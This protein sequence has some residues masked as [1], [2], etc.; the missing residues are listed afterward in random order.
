M[1]VVQYNLRFI[2]GFYLPSTLE[3]QHPYGTSAEVFFSHVS[4]PSCGNTK[5]HGRVVCGEE[6]HRAHKSESQGSKRSNNRDVATHGT[7]D[8]KLVYYAD[9]EFCKWSHQNSTL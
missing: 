2:C 5:S 3:Y 4:R 1:Q 9:S 7:S 8:P 6:A